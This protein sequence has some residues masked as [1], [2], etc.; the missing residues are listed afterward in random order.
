MNRERTTSVNRKT[1]ETEIAIT[2]DL[3]GTGRYEVDTGVPFLDHMLC[4]WT[5]HG[6]FDLKLQARG[7]V[8]ID[9]HHTVEDIGICMGKA[10]DTCLGDKKGISRY[11]HTITPM[12]EALVLI[13]VDISGRGY[14]AYDVEFPSSQVGNF[15]TELVEEFLRALAANAKITLHVKKFAGRN[16]HH[17]IEAIFK[18]LGRSLKIAAGVTGSDSLPST[19]GV[20]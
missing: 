7:D 19:K 20:L 3:D 17:I 11:G 8:H 1:A 4:L 5:K 15:D 18:G 13:A 9:Y 6:S 16:C 12:D 14:L 2:L 10:L